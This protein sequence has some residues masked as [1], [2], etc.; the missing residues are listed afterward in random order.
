MRVVTWNMGCGPASRYAR[1]HDAAWCYLLDFLRPDLAFVQEALTRS[2]DVVC[3]R[4]SL[5]WSSRRPRHGSGTAVFI[6]SGIDFVA[7]DDVVHG[8]Y[9]A[10]AILRAAD[11]SIRVASIHV[12]PEEWANQ[13]ALRKWLFN[14]VLPADHFIV[15]GDLN[16]SR[17]YS[18]RHK[19]YLSSL[20]T[21]GL[22]DC[23]WALHESESPSF[24]G[25]PAAIAKYQDDHLFTSRSMSR[26]VLECG[27]VDNPLTRVLS[28]H[29]PLALDLDSGLR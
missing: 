6:R 7:V 2:N 15:G 20:T 23:R 18:K 22:H 4:G 19:E 16:T 1:V 13:L 11:R 3:S 26:N 14:N 17:A 21:G 10:G 25:G 29:G 8:S 28:D 27:V 24:W 9:V 12:G 5:V